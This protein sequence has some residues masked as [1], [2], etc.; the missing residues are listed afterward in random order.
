MVPDALVPGTM[1]VHRILPP[2]CYHRLLPDPEVCMRII[3]LASPILTL[4]LVGGAVGQ[5]EAGHEKDSGVLTKAMARA[6]VHNK[7][8]LALL[9]ADGEDL[10][11]T[12]KKNRAISRTLLYEFEIVQ[13]TGVEADAWAERLDYPDAVKAKPA[14]AVLDSSGRVL[15]RMQGTELATEGEENAKGFLGRL[16]PH[17]AEPVDAEKKLADGLAE[18][19][20][21][22][23]NVF[24]RFDAPW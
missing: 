3:A 7:R 18:A 13:F 11:G 8:V 5:E 9:V 20:K 12:W 1:N 14:M 17:F 22:G 21:S 16:K 19:K 24:V 23:R 10:A 2:R 6:D 4:A 15:A